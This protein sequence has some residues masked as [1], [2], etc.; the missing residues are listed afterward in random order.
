LFVTGAAFAQ[1]PDGL[2]FGG[3]G[4]AVFVPLQGEFENGGDT[5]FRSGVGAGWKPAYMGLNIRFSAADGRVGGAA[6]ISHGEAGNDVGVGDNL[7]IWAK[8]FAT[9]ILY[10]AVGKI[11]DGRFRGLG[12]VD[13]D[14]NGWIGGM[15]SSGDPVFTR[16]NSDGLARGSALFISQP[17]TGLSF[18][19]QLKPGWGTISTQRPLSTAR[20]AGDIYKTLQAGFAYDIAGIGLA[21]AQWFGDTMDGISSTVNVTTGATEWS[22]NNAR[23]EAAFKLTAVKGLNLDIGLKLPIPVKE[24]FFGV[25]AIYQGNFEINVIGDFK[26]GDFGVAFGLYSAFAGSLA[27]DFPGVERDSLQSRFQIIAIPSFYVAAID[28]TVGAD[29]GFRVEGES[30]FQGADQDN[31]GTTFGIGAWISRDLGKGKIKTGLAFQFPKYG[32]NGT[33][34]ETSYLTWP[35]ILEVSF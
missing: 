3:W 32:S 24:D 20:E 16:F 14:Y 8:P 26:T 27:V 19:A 2:S 31:E 1:V 11:V 28:A 18:F 22:A 6:D 10:I 33:I 12:S 9:D 21:R 5:V 35:I 23:I 34:G 17:I 4:R 13:D 30:D 15:G 25:D 7:N 29:V